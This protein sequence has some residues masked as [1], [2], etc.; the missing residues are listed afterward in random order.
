MK[1]RDVFAEIVPDDDNENL[2][3]IGKK[4]THYRERGWEKM[5]TERWNLLRGLFVLITGMEKKYKMAGKLISSPIMV[6]SCVIY[7]QSHGNISQKAEGPTGE[8]EIVF[9]SQRC[10]DPRDDGKWQ[11]PAASSMQII[12]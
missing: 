1:S 12:N 11:S 10:P 4:L 6:H 8:L 9:L 5:E 3:L 2:F 7:W